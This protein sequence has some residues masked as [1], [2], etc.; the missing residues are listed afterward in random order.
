[1]GSIY[2]YF[3]HRVRCNPAGRLGQFAFL[4]LQG[5]ADDGLARH[6]GKL[7]AL[8]VVESYRRLEQSRAE[9]PLDCEGIASVL[10]C[11]TGLVAPL[12]KEDG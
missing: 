11:L 12:Y 6:R 1:M 10:D 3:P 4:P 7:C 9:G 2:G 8:D 5:C